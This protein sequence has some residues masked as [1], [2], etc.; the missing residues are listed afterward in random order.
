LTIASW[1]MEHL[2]ASDGSGCR[3]RT[4]ADYAALRAYADQIDADVVA[5]QEVESAAAAA[6]VFDPSRWTI[7]IEQRAGSGRRGECGGRPGLYLTRQA[8]GFAVRR[9]LQLGRHPDF[10][11]LQIGQDD[12]RSGV[13]VTVSRRRGV[14][15]R[16]LSVH[17]KSGCASGATGSPCETLFRQIPVLERWIDLRAS[18]GERFA[19]LG[20][21]NRRLAA[22][23]D[24][25]WSE[26]DDGEPINADL[27]YASG[28]RTAGCDPRYP[29]F[30]DHMVLDRT[31]A[32]GV[33]EFQEHVYVGERLSDHCAISVEVAG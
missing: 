18:E 23:S 26:L 27:A 5:F 3:P 10:V 31:A 19:V 21:F 33:G 13:D 6:R 29:Q 17:L 1:N 24:R 14:P 20:D 4:P 30:I 7:L 2:A 16:L 25:V 9:E 15:I 28:A 32:A 12:L 8:V 11:E 22:P